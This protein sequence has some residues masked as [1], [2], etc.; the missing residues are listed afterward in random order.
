MLPA[1]LAV[2]PNF[3]GRVSWALAGLLKGNE[4]VGHEGQA[5][6]CAPFQALALGSSDIT[7][8]CP[9]RGFLLEFV[10]W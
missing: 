10:S 2:L 3:P 8:F 7:R 1:P 4:G 5:G 9:S 6:V